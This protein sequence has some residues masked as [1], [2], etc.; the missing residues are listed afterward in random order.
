MKTLL[1]FAAVLVPC[2]AAA[3]NPPCGTNG[4][5]QINNHGKCAAVTPTG[6]LVNYNP[7]QGTFSIDSDAPSVGVIRN[8]INAQVSNAVYATGTTTYTSGQYTAPG[9]VNPLPSILQ[10]GQIYNI[11]FN[12]TNP[13]AANLQIGSLSPKS[14]KILDGYGDVLSLV[15]GE[16]VPGPAVV[17]YDGSEFI[18]SAPFSVSKKVTGAMNVTQQDFASQTQFYLS[19]GSETITLPCSNTLSPNGLI[20]VFSVS[21]TAT[22]AVGSGC[23]DTV[24]KNGSSGTTATVAQGAGDATITT[25]GAGNFY[26]SGQ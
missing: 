12:Q 17:L 16:I 4:Q 1:A 24:Y 22:L 26:V 7:S 14:L 18:Y 6:D 19:A 8:S 11:T 15:G 20:K 13:S 3:Y 10:A 9:G 5:L 23:S 25:D 21:G 2:L